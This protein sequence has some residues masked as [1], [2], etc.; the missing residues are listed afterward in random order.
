MKTKLF[1][2]L[3]FVALLTSCGDTKLPND[4]VFGEI[5]NMVLDYHSQ[6]TEL[7]D[8]VKAKD[9]EDLK[10]L[11]AKYKEMNKA[12]EE[13]MEQA[14][15]KYQGKEI[16]TEVDKNVFIKFDK[17]FTIKK[18][19]DNGIVTIVG[20]GELTA[21][22]SSIPG[23]GIIDYGRLAIVLQNSE[24]EGFYTYNL[25]QMGIEG[26]RKNDVYPKGTK[27]KYGAYIKMRPWNI[28]NMANA[29]SLIVTDRNR[30]IYTNANKV[31][32]DAEKAMMEAAK[33]SKD[34]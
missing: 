8:N 25:F 5:P 24:S 4:G 23:K 33:A 31:D 19:D 13:Q 30:D 27:I 14:T 34:K 3:A 16:P 22:G 7:T 28:E 26:E 18:I 2:L 9:A 1:S 20:E 10:V 6:K 15:E 29:K 32:K 11:F 21:E 17:P 12:F